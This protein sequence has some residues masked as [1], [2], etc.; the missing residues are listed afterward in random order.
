[1]IHVNLLKKNY[2]QIVPNAQTKIQVSQ[3]QMELVIHNRK[4][5]I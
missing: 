1:M 2:I 5:A 3:Q 4:R